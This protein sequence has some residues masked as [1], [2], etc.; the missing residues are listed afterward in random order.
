MGRGP[1][2]LGLQLRKTGSHSRLFCGEVTLAAF[3][4]Y[5]FSALEVGEG[6]SEGGGW[7]QEDQLEAGAA[8][9]RR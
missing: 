5:P 2:A 3:H 4:K 7:R 9:P 1:V 8:A 6:R